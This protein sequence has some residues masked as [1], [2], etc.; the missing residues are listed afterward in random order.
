MVIDDQIQNGIQ[1][2][3]IRKRIILEI[4]TSLQNE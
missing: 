1:K 4:Q 2:V 3:C